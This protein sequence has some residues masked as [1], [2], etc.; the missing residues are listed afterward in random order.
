MKRN[1]TKAVYNCVDILNDVYK[2]IAIKDSVTD[3]F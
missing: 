1:E 3:I 2:F